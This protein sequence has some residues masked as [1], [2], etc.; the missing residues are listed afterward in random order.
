[1]TLWPSGAREFAATMAVGRLATCGSD[2][3]P[4]AVPICFAI[5]GDA[6]Y[7]VVDAKPKSAPLDLKRLR[8]VAENPR[9][10]V[11]IDHYEADWR[12]L[13]YV[14]L[15]GDALAVDDAREYARALEALRTKYEQYRSMDFDPASNPM[16]R[17]TIRRVV[18]WRYTPSA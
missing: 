2:G 6:L 11:V 10:A 18:Y 7:S 5:R 16:L 8:N 12:R 14:M 3:M 1:V 9:A 13:A 17:I 15:R 4:H